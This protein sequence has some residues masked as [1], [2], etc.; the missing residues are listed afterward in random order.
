VIDYCRDKL[1]S[2]KRPKAVIF[3]AEMPMRAGK[4]VKRELIELVKARVS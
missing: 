3:L 1:A 2:Y 4:V